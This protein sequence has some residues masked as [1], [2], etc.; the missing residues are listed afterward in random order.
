MYGTERGEKERRGGN[1]F[2]Y[3]NG[4]PTN[5]FCFYLVKRKKRT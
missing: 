1:K 5:S 4:Y 3:M 2:G